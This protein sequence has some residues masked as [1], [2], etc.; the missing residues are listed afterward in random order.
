MTESGGGGGGVV[1]DRRRG[2]GDNRRLWGEVFFYLEKGKCGD[3]D[4]LRGWINY[5]LAYRE[6]RQIDKKVEQGI[7]G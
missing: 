2:V 7:V 3:G 1:V 4:S 6:K 5:I